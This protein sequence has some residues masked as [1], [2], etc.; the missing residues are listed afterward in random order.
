MSR[1]CKNCEHW[2]CRYHSKELSYGECAIADNDYENDT[3]I[4]PA[5]GMITVA[6]IE[7]FWTYLNTGPN[8]FCNRFKEKE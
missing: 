1:A 7:S 8:A 5:D 3:N 2:E 4:P 6:G